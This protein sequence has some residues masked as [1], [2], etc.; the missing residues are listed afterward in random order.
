MRLKFN[1]D[2]V[3]KFNEIILLKVLFKIHVFLTSLVTDETWL[4]T[5]VEGVMWRLEL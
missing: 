2:L 5:Y 3:L 4:H 1:K